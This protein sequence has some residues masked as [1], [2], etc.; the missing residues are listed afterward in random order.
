M[1]QYIVVLFMESPQCEEG[2]VQARVVLPF[3]SSDQR[4]AK[5][6][7]ETLHEGVR[8]S[9]TAVKVLSINNRKV[10]RAMIPSRGVLSS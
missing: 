3:G 1:A 9:V 10:N 6:S 7:L 2:D 8:G 5:A 4:I